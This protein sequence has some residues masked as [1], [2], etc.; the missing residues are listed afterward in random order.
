MKFV[1]PRLTSQHFWDQMHAVPIAALAEIEQ[2]IVGE[3]LA[4]EQYA[5]RC[6][7]WPTIRPT[8]I[9]TLPAP[10]FGPNY[11]NGGTTSRGVMT[12]GSWVWHWSW[13][14]PRSCRWP[15]A[16][17]RCPLGHEDLFGVS[18]TG[19]KAA[20]QLQSRRRAVDSGLRCR[21]LVAGQ[22]RESGYQPG[23]LC[24]G[25][26]PFFPQGS[27]GPSRRSSHPGGVIYRGDGAGLAHAVPDRGP[28]TRRRGGLQSAVV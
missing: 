1:A 5:C 11:P 22:P 8:S 12:C 10:T 28:T 9:P 18:R 7:R 3:V 21:G 15:C 25:S 4:I 14:R 13:T 26:T 16:L 19:A 2:R 27:A 6:R 17:R 20:A 24:N 23:S